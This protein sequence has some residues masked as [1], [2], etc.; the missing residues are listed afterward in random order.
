MSA[1][2]VQTTPEPS[3]A[4]VPRLLLDPRQA[5]EA[6]G[7]SERSLFSL[8]KNG[9]VPSLKLGRLRRYSLVELQPTRLY[10]RD[11]GISGQQGKSLRM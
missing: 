2:T 1:P 3:T 8:T 6:L 5:A 9:E 4:P 7:L 11:K 10:S